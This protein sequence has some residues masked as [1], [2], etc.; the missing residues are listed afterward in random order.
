MS[1]HAWRSSA[2]VF[3]APPLSAQTASQLIPHKV[4]AGIGR[5][6]AASGRS[7]SREDG[8]V[9]NGEAY[10]VVEGRR[11]SQWRD[12]R[13]TGGQSRR[14][15]R[16]RR[17][18]LYW[19]RLPSPERPVRVHLPAVRPTAAPTTRSAAIIPRSTART[20]IS[21]SRC[22]ANMR[23]KSMRATSISSRAC[24]PA[25]ASRWKGRRRA[26]MSTAPAGALPDRERPQAR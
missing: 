20:R 7:R 5:L 11:L 26:C 8:E 16:R 3:V 14:R 15:R 19:H 24:G 22:P 9:A 2:L 23:R 1:V 10:A 6:P 13:G 18:R 12:R 25:T 4:K 17:A 21:A